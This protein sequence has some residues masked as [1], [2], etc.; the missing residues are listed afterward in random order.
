MVDIKTFDFDRNLF[1]FLVCVIFLFFS[2]VQFIIMH[3]LS[4]L[5]FHHWFVVDGFSLIL[6]LLLKI[7]TFQL[8][9]ACMHAVHTSPAPTLVQVVDLYGGYN[10]LASAEW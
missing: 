6:N 3:V 2:E 4:R 8:A 9:Y 1:N 10:Y 5:F 7:S